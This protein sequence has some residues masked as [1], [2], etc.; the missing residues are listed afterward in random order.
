MYFENFGS[1]ASSVFWQ[2]AGPL[3]LSGALQDRLDHVR[4]LLVA[5]VHAFFM[6]SAMRNATRTL[7]SLRADLVWSCVWSLSFAMFS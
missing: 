3:G 2:F 6:P 7:R 4:R 5:Q 1:L